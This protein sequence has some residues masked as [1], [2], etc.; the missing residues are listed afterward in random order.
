[1]D[2]YKGIYYGNDDDRKFYEGG[3][4]FKYSSLYKILEMLSL[5]INPIPQK[6]INNSESFNQHFSMK[7]VKHSAFNKKTRNIINFSYLSGTNFKTE[8]NNLNNQKEKLDSKLKFNSLKKNSKPKINSNYNRGSTNCS[9]KINNVTK[10]KNT[11]P[12]KI[13][14]RNIDFLTFRENASSIIKKSVPNCINKTKNKQIS[15]SLQKIKTEPKSKLYNYKQNI[16]DYPI[17]LKNGLTGKESNKIIKIDLKNLKKLLKP[18]NSLNPNNNKIY[19][20]YRNNS[21]IKI[22][23]QNSDLNSLNSPNFTNRKS[24]NMKNKS[25]NKNISSSNK[26]N[27]LNEKRIQTKKIIKKNKENIVIDNKILS[28][29]KNKRTKLFNI[30]S[31]FKNDD[32]KI[33]I[34]INQKKSRN[35]ENQ[36]FSFNIRP[37]FLKTNQEKFSN[38]FKSL[39]IKNVKKNVIK[40]KKN[41][42]LNYHKKIN[43]NIKTG[44]LKEND[45]V[46]NNI[47]TKFFN[48][49]NTCR[50]NES[51]NTKEKNNLLSRKNKSKCDKITTNDHLSHEEI[52]KPLDVL[53]KNEGNKVNKNGKKINQIIKIT[54]NKS[55]LKSDKKSN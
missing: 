46:N 29:K 10:I 48:S 21:I 45:N 13:N 19:K 5:K 43:L 39:I 35:C 25:K 51:F 15:I 31:I 28:S 3:A 6:K 37:D 2:E 16:R 9:S 54:L 55:D 53:A 44:F 30:D 17:P 22:D 20:S 49:C 24:F 40:Y 8:T 52:K 18:N 12:K 27:H 34:N 38:C 41:K 4:H 32:K 7:K 47:S 42:N 26:V 11:I 33:N 36:D 1:M 14:T 50:I 23:L